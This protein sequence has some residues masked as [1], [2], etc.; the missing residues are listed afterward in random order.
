TAPAGT[1]TLSL[2]DALPIS[3]RTAALPAGRHTVA[4]RELDPS[5]STRPSDVLR[6][7]GPVVSE[8]TNAVRDVDARARLFRQSDIGD[9]VDEL[10]A[11][12][13]REPLD[14]EL[15]M[16]AGIALYTAR[17][18]RS[19]LLHLRA[20]LLLDDRL[21][22]AALYLGLCLDS[23]GDPLR[24]R[25]EYRHAAFLVETGMAQQVP[26]PGPLEGFETELLAMVRTK[27]RAP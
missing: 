27:A 15:R 4:S 25:A 17:D 2:H 22:P 11:T 7:D 3:A 16:L 21:W 23:M 6:T 19:G 8:N 12:S 18:Y 20:A 10:L 13:A 5:S 9:A 24:A 26:L 14:A 1:Y